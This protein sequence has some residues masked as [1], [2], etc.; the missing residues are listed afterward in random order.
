M[1][2]VHNPICL[3]DVHKMTKRPNAVKYLKI[4]LP[5]EKYIGN[6]EEFAALEALLVVV[7]S[8]QPEPSCSLVTPGSG[9]L[10]LSTYS[11]VQ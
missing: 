3:G 11:T 2:K 8:A 10:W 9:E 7:T 5:S 4:I 6:T 1:G